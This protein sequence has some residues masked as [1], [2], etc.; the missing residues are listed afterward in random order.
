M[1]IRSDDAA[2]GVA[3]DLHQGERDPCA[4]DD[5]VRRRGVA[6]HRRAVE[7]R[8]LVGTGERPGTHGLGLGRGHPPLPGR[9]AGRAGHGRLGGPAERVATEFNDHKREQ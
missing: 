7:Q 6:G 4:G 1:P 2:I 3:H 8:A 9:A 5:R